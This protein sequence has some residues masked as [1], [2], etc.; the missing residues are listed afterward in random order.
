MT[1]QNHSAT[2]TLTTDDADRLRRGLVDEARSSLQ[3]TPSLHGGARRSRTAL[4]GAAAFV[5]L[6]VGFVAF[7]AGRTPPAAEAMFTVT[8]HGDWIDISPN[9]DVETFDPDAAVEEL[10]AIG[11]K[12]ERGTYVQ[13][14]EENGDLNT[15]AP[16]T[17]G[18]SFSSH[19]F[20]FGDRTEVIFNIEGPVG[21][22]CPVTPDGTMLDWQAAAEEFGFRN[23]MEQRDGLELRRD[24]PITIW[25]LTAP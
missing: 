24:A 7:D 21:A 16:E 5:I 11:F 17:E 15:K 23:P 6:V 13:W 3:A 9:L 2:A 8:P 19:G 20:E 14:R 25:V 10:R 18:L 1:R 4:V 22:E 12:A